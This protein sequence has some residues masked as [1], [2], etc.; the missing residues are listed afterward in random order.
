MAIASNAPSKFDPNAVVRIYAI[1]S[2]I[3][4]RLHLQVHRLE[5]MFDYIEYR[6]IPREINNVSDWLANYIMDQ[7][8]THI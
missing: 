5:R 3:L 1:R 2:P 7:Y 4:L 8:L 6:H